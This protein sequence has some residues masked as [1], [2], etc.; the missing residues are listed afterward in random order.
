[1]HVNCVR[2]IS[3]GPQIDVCRLHITKSFEKELKLKT[4]IAY[5]WKLYLN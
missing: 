1:M 2:V 5:A 4:T 3:L